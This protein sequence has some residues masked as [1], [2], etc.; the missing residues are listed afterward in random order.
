MNSWKNPELSNY[1]VLLNQQ[2]PNSFSFIHWYPS[3]CRKLHLLAMM[4]T[5]NSADSS[6]IV[7]AQQ[8]SA[9]ST[10]MDRWK[11]HSMQSPIKLQLLKWMPRHLTISWI[12]YKTQKTMRHNVCKIWYF[13]DVFACVN[14]MTLTLSKIPSIVNAKSTTEPHY[15]KIC[16][17]CHAK[18]SMIV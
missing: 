9:C 8:N 3:F 16:L 4:E 15:A 12:P 1:F 5:Q 13:V 6:G 17:S 18:R 10:R 11:K 7:R 2:N 14:I